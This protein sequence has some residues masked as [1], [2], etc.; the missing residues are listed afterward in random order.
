MCYY[1]MTQPFPMYC[2]SREF[3]DIPMRITGIFTQYSREQVDTVD[4]LESN[5]S[6]V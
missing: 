4:E 5:N 1:S 2:K 6:L 3:S